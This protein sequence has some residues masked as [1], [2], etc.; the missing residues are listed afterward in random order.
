MRSEISG[1]SYVNDSA[2]GSSGRTSLALT[3][4]MIHLFSLFHYPISHTGIHILMLG[5][6]QI[7]DI[8]SDL[9]WLQL[10][11]P[12]LYPLPL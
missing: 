10:Q 7:G 8:V 11:T 3:I 12:G 9:T 2:S 5:A 1:S 4:A 6:G